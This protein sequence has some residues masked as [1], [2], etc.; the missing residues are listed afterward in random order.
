L[1]WTPTRAARASRSATSSADPSRRQPRLPGQFSSLTSAGAADIQSFRGLPHQAARNMSGPG[2]DALSDLCTSA[3]SG[4]V[5]GTGGKGSYGDWLS[6]VEV[7]ISAFD[8]VDGSV[9]IY[10]RSMV[11]KPRTRTDV[12]GGRLE[13]GE[14]GARHTIR[15]VWFGAHRVCR[16]AFRDAQVCCWWAGGPRRLSHACHKWCETWWDGAGYV[17]TV[18]AGRRE[19]RDEL[20]R[21]TMVSR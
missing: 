18:S 17:E 5:V 8:V 20:G 2:A 21:V 11:G 19:G 3:G 7:K 9:R 1:P 14:L 6:A 16:R 15:A 12:E 13:S 10:I 4:D